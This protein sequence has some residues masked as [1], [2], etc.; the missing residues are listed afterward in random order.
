MI[1]SANYPRTISGAPLNYLWSTP[2]LTQDYLQPI[3]GPPQYHPGSPYTIT[4]RPSK[5]NP[6]VATRPTTFDP[7]TNHLRISLGSSN[8]YEIQVNYFQNC[9]CVL[10]HTYYYL[11]QLYN[12]NFVKNI[13]QLSN[14]VSIIN[15][16][17]TW[18]HIDFF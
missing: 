12:K 17:E 11:I 14:L 1:Q 4:S 2:G 16:H 9:F 10:K 6:R 15:N 13:I 5:D 18:Q 8:H 3:L 7:L